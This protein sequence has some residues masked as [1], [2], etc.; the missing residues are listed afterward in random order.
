MGRKAK[1]DAS[2]LTLE[3]LE[4][5]IEAEAQEK[6]LSENYFFRTTFERYKNQLQILKRLKYCIDTE[7]TLVEKSYQKDK[8]NLYV[9]PA[10]SEYNKTASAANGTVATLIKILTSLSGNPTEGSEPADLM[11]EF[12]RT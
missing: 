12:L 11:S 8:T 4:K 10:I 5:K 2:K 1:S 3:D 9:N 7:E 6:G